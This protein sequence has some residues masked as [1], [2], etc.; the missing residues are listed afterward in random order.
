MRGCVILRGKLELLSNNMFYFYCVT[1]SSCKCK[2]KAIPVTGREGPWGCERLRLAHFLDN[3]HTDGGEVVSIMRRPPFT[4][5]KILVLIS[6][7]RL[8]RPLDHSTAE[9]IRSVKIL[10]TSSGTEP[11]TFRLVAQCLNQLRYGVPPF[12]HLLTP[13]YI[14]KII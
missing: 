1:V 7:I 10:M 11:A 12:P 9:R 8:S 3:P 2:G 4:R 13:N 5:R 6:V 14:Y